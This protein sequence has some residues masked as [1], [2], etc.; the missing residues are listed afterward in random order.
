M[1]TIYSAADLM[2]APSPFEAFGFVYV[3]A[4]AC[5][6]PP[7]GCTTGGAP[8]VIADGDGGVLVEPANPSA[9][10]SCLSTLID[11]RARRSRLSARGRARVCRDFTLD[12]MVTRTET[13]YRSVLTR[14][15]AA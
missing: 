4:M 12:A 2:V 15:V 8:E 13:F 11:D 10:A 1:P 9:L 3:E 6:C 7:V 14:D 5:G